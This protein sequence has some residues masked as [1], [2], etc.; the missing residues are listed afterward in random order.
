MRPVRAQDAMVKPEANGNKHMVEAAHSNGNT[1]KAKKDFHPSD[2]IKG[3]WEGVLRPYS[4]EEA[5]L[6]ASEQQLMGPPGWPTQQ[7]AAGLPLATQLKAAARRAPALLYAPACQQ[8]AP[9]PCSADT[10]GSTCSPLCFLTKTQPWHPAQV[11][12]LRGS[13]KVQYTVADVTAR[14]LWKYMKEDTFVPALG[15][16]TGNQAIQMVRGGLKSVYCSGWQVWPPAFRNSESHQ[17]RS[18]LV[19]PLGMRTA[20]SNQAV[21]YITGGGLTS[22]CSGCSGCGLLCNKDAQAY[23]WVL[24]AAEFALPRAGVRNRCQ[25][26]ASHAEGLRASAR[27]GCSGWKGWGPGSSPALGCSVAASCSRTC[28]LGP[29]QPIATLHSPLI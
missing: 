25:A 28:R 18:G 14:K 15:A 27:V 1:K 19:R 21:R 24:G 6:S 8:T 23:S 13:L 16:V 2:G 12:K 9:S 7:P 10:G 22:V 20:A 29:A 5:S 4:N 3:R 26:H 17:H 11:E